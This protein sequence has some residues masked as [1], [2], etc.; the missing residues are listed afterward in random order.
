M[1][2]E[3]VLM[4]CINPVSLANKMSENVDRLHISEEAK[5]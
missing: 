5:G 1:V 3:L 4:S 2:I